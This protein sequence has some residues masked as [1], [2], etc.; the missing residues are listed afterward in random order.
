MSILDGMP[1][2]EA[3]WKRIVDMAAPFY[4]YI[5]K[6]FEFTP[7]QRKVWQLTNQGIPLAD[8]LGITKEEREA[9]LA[10]ACKLIKKG[11]YEEA[12]S[13][14]LQL[15][16]LY[17]YDGRVVYTTGITLQLEGK[18]F[19]AGKVFVQAI[20]MD[21][22]NPEGY[23]R[24]GECFLVEREY[25]NAAASFEGAE[26]LCERGYGNPKIHQYASKMLAHALER[27]EATNP[28]NRR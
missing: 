20:G 8:I 23:L 10:H 28:A 26:D 14:L 11:Q 6:N 5:E 1:Q 13:L 4:E 22:T 27:I 19:A 12:R 21:A 2:S 24:L 25:H 17:P 7:E 9:V 15:I 3:Q 16:K 18:A